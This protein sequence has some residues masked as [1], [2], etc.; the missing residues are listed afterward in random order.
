MKL[1]FKAI[2]S[3]PLGTIVKIGKVFSTFTCMVIVQY[4]PTTEDWEKNPDGTK[5]KRLLSLGTDCPHEVLWDATI[6]DHKDLEIIGKYSGT[7]ED[8]DD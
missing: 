1:T 6:K 8:K 4:D 2:Q 3:L 5:L 7:R